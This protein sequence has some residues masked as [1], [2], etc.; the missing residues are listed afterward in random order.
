MIP[1]SSGTNAPAAAPPIELSD[2]ESAQLR[3][4]AGW[5]RFTAIAGLITYGLVTLGYLTMLITRQAG[6]LAKPSFALYFAVAGVGGVAATALALGYGRGVR[7]FF[8]HGEPALTNAF[9]RL[10]LFFI[11]WTLLDALAIVYD[12]LT[13]LA[14]R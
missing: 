6:E 2:R 10:R 7:L 12:V 8:T 11:L 9:R 4:A 5:A 13:L 3:R 14:K 1:P